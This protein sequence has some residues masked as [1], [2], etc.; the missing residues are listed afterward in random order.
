MTPSSP[1]TGMSLLE[2]ALRGGAIMLLLLRIAV[3]LKSARYSRVSWYSALLLASIAAYVVESAPGFDTLDV[4]VRLPVHI[5]ISGTPAIFWVTMGTLFV[6]DFR[7]RW[8][9]AFA[10]L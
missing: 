6:D 2:A 5:V 4:S 9:H 8:H 7:P 1:I 10:W 3:L